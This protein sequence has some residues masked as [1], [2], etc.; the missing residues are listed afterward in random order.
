MCVADYDGDIGASV[1]KAEA[2]PMNA[3]VNFEVCLNG[4]LVTIYE[5]K[6]M[7]TIFIRP[8]R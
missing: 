4:Q 7:P 8:F 5:G 6:T 2:N 3:F 1:S